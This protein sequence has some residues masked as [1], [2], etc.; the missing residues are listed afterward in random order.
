[1]LWN[2]VLVSLGT[3][4]CSRELIPPSLC[5]CAWGGAQFDYTSS[6][7]DAVRGMAV[8]SA[9]ELPNGHGNDRSTDSPASSAGSTFPGHSRISMDSSVVAPSRTSLD[10]EKNSALLMGPGPQPGADQGAVTAYLD[11]MQRGGLI[12][13]FGCMMLL[14]E[15]SLRI[16][17]FSENTAEMLGYSKPE[18][19][20]LT[21]QM[22]AKPKKLGQRADSKRGVGEFRRK[23]HLVQENHHPWHTTC[24]RDDM[25]YSHTRMHADGPSYLESPVCFPHL[26]AITCTFSPR[27]SATG[28]VC[29]LQA[30]HC[31]P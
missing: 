15:K 14:D 31:A 24:F 25:P 22:E 27:S 28:L 5:F 12:Q 29:A 30:R 26:L 10:S 3:A 23:F 18:E 2:E 16:L 6:V 21:N 4:L 20:F 19:A 17:A 7:V 11:R 13:S 1:M 8:S 9:V